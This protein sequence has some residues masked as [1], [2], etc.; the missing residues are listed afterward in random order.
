VGQE[1][2]IYIYIYIHTHT[3]IHIYT[4]THT[5]IHIYIYIYIEINKEYLHTSGIGKET[6]GGGKE[7]QIVNNKVYHI[8]VGT[9]HIETR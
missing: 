2:F 7:G 6:K 1:Y 5:Y 9:R 3:H 4:H 8:C